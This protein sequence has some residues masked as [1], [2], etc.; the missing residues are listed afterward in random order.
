MVCH[1]INSAIPCQASSRTTVM[2]LLITNLVNEL[3]H[4]SGYHISDPLS[5]PPEMVTF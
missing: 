2:Q 5:P 1:L 4:G 3:L